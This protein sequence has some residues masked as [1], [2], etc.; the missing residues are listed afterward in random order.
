VIHEIRAA[1][2]GTKIEVLIPD[3]NGDPEA[4][5][6]VL[7][8]RPEILNH[9]T[10]TV[11]RLYRAMRPRA[12]YRQSIELLRR[13]AAWKATYPVRTK[14]GLMLGL[15]E[16]GS[17]IEAVLR[18]LRDADCDILTLGQYLQPTPDHAPVARFV[19]PDEFAE[20]KRAGLAMGFLHVESGPLVR[21]SYHAHEQ[22]AGL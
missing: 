2:P 3:F 6:A 22:A 14:S 20:W 8:A 12:D 17:E 10:E 15:G 11:P 21:S 7:D 19:H 5:R 13:A 1:S 18:D 16:D 9:N 4:L